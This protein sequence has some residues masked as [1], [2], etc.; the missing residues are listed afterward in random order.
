MAEASDELR[1]AAAKYV[2]KQA[3]TLGI[4]MTLQG[5]TADVINYEVFSSGAYDAAVL[6]WMVGRY[7][8]YLCEWFG[9]AKPF[10]Y[11]PSTVTSLCGELEATS[12]LETAQGKV[13]E[14]QSALAQD[15]PMIPLYSGVIREP[16]RNVA[17]P[18][19]S[20]LDGLRGVYGA[21]GLAMPE[22]P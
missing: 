13:R 11:Q 18:F 9:P 17:Y 4:Q 2:Q 20:V 1:M 12:D 5:T 7:P 15:V 6:G 14:I 16:Y 10:Q 22:S 8:G 3:G 21:P 19:A